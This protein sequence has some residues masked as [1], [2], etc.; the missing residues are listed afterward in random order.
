MNITLKRTEE[1]LELVKAMASKDRDVA[2]EAQAA[3]AEFIAPVLAEVIQQAP[4]LSNMFKTL[5]FTADDNPSIPLDLY[6][7]IADED[8]IEI[9]SQN[10]PGGLP[11]NQV[12]PT[13][14]ELKFTTYRLDSALS[15]DKKY[16]ARSR[17]DV[18]SKTFTRM[19]QELL[20]KMET[21]SANMILAAL[22]VAETNGVSHSLVNTTK[23]R[24][25][26]HDFN[27]LLTVSKRIHTS[28]T[29]GTPTGGVSGVT[30]LIVS[31]EVVE[32]LR[33][34]A[35]NPVNTRGLDSTQTVPKTALDG[36]EMPAHTIDNSGAGVIP[37]TD[38]M[39]DAIYSNGGIPEFYGINIQE[40][41]E[42]G[43]GA[44]YTK[45]WRSL[46]NTGTPITQ[47]SVD[48]ADDDLILGI[49]RS[50][51]DMM[52]RAVATDADNGSELSLVPDD[53]FVSRQQKVGYYGSLEEGRMILDNR[54]LYGMHVDMG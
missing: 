49:D 43:P 40:S 22:A 5:S 35:Y 28:F 39:R 13:T 8:Y 10:A 9:W 16:V 52:V 15:F 34:M 33:E 26:L 2:Y 53:Q 23:G 51:A 1:Q 20:L 30:D 29:G 27:K 31:P 11:S 32:N 6:F 36:G 19:A 14:Q 18:L 41:L 48:A 4:T 54:V 44:K 24:I 12:A 45:V 37:A 42:F 50:R 47:S 38:S 25:L 21:T 7:D 46:L 3:L 17:M